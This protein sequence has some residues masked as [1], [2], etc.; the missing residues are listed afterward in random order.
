MELKP[1]KLEEKPLVKR[2][3]PVNFKNKVHLV[4]VKFQIVATRSLLLRIQKMFIINKANR[5]SKRKRSKS[6]LLV[7]V[8]VMM[9]NR[10]VVSL[11]LINNLINIRLMAV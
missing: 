10:K 2:L 3:L 7:L 6:K 8:L 5:S 4:K 1:H 9:K 11:N